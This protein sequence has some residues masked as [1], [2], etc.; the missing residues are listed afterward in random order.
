MSADKIIR[1]VLRQRHAAGSSVFVPPS[2][3][4]GGFGYNMAQVVVVDERWSR[5][6]LLRYSYPKETAR[7]LSFVWVRGN[8]ITFEYEFHH[9]HQL[10]GFRHCKV[11]ACR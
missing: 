8:H 1:L 9:L 11:L 4:P 5:D 2:R 7:G 3:E 10:L 6:C